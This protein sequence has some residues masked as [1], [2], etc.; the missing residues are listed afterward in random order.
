LAA[1]SD[2][3]WEGIMGATFPGLY[4]MIARLHMHKYGTT[5]EQMAEVA[6]KNHSNGFL[7]PISQYRR[8]I[9][10][11]DVLSSILV[12]D[13]LHILDCSPITDGASSLVLAPADIAHEYTDTPVYI[14]ASSQ[15]SDTISL[16]DRKDITTLDSTVAAANRAYEMAKMKPNDIDLVEVHDCFTIAEICAIEDLGFVKKGQGGSFTQEG[17]TSIGGKIPVNTSGGLKSCGHPVGATGIKQAVEVVHQLRG[18]AGKRQLDNANIGM[19]HNVGG[20]GAT[21]VVHILARDR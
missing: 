18:E 13:P 16:H 7:N 6:V 2:R 12:A 8:K 1:A 4:A 11:E 14:K 20:S 17:E 10:V 3:E 19:T 15:A 9:T 21:A 5:S